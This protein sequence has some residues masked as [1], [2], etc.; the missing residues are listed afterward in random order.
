[1]KNLCLI[2]V[3]G[4]M[5]GMV[6]ARVEV[7]HAT[8]AFKKEF[9]QKYVKKEPG[10]DA[11]KA[12]AEAYAKAKCNVCHVGATKKKRNSYGQALN[13]MITKKD[14][15][16]KGKIQD[17][18]DKAAKMK[19][20]EGDDSSPTFGELIEQGKLPGGEPA[21]AAAAAGPGE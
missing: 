20:K 4:F 5:A 11:E 8:D 18:L 10:S 6:L 2:V 13:T 9:E 1:M 21:A 14:I 15:K 3:V 16:D 17:A 12:L 7:V 19:S